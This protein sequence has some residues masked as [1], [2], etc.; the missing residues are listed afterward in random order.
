MQTGPARRRQIGSL[1]RR[2]PRMQRRKLV[3]LMVTAA[4]LFSAM[5]QMAAAQR[6]S[7]FWD[8]DEFAR[9]MALLDMEPVGPADKP[10]LQALDPTWVD[11]SQYKKDPPWTICFS[12]AGLFN[13][14]RVVGFTTMQ[15]TVEANPL[16]KEFIV[17][18]AEGRDEKQI[19]D[20]A[21]L[22]ASGKCDLLI[23]SPM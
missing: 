1:E 7:E 13:P 20:I 3:A 21:D 12:N 22:V 17:L 23:V 5:P 16:I 11:T 9:Q 4:L 10:W 2:T 8:P 14:W 18:D 6:V 19:A 15:A